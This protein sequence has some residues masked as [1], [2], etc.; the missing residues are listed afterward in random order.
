MAAVS[1]SADAYYQRYREGLITRHLCRN[2]RLLQAVLLVQENE[3]ALIAQA[4]RGAEAAPGQLLP[5]RRTTHERTLDG[6][7]Y[8]YAAYPVIMRDRF[9]IVG[10]GDNPL[11]SG[12]LAM[13]QFSIESL[14]GVSRHSLGYATLLLK[15]FE[16]SQVAPGK[17]MRRR[18]FWRDAVP[19]SKDELSGMLLGLTFFLQAT[20]RAGDTAAHNRGKAFMRAVGEYLRREKY[21]PAFCWVFQFPF[22]RLFK[23]D[24]GT[25]LLSGVTIPP[26]P[27]TGDELGDLILKIIGN[28]LL[29]RLWYKPKHLYRD[30][31]R[32][33]PVAYQAA[34]GLDVGRK[35]FNVAMYCHTAQMI[36]DKP[37]KA[38]VRNELWRSFQ[39]MF[40]YFARSG[41]RPG[42]GEGRQNALL[43]VVAHA[44]AN[45]VG[46]R[47]VVARALEMYRPILRPEGVWAPSLP[48]CCLP[49]ADPMQNYYGNTRRYWGERFTWEHR[50]PKGH[51]LRWD[52]TK[53][54]GS[55]GPQ[56]E[57][58]LKADRI[59]GAPYYH[60]DPARGFVVE[61]V[62]QGLP[63][64]RALAAYYG[65]CPAPVL[66]VDERHPVLPLD[67]PAP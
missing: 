61:A 53:C 56:S 38:S 13:A 49:G 30:S 32:Y 42:Q 26:D 24:L 60:A 6:R 34:T 25:A 21:E 41:S 31:M 35:F 66:S 45:K 36:F 2:G 10:G 8:R 5:H 50:D 39:T 28:S 46:N 9:R 17:L 22:T 33:L 43:G 23:F 54:L 4:A 65:L 57:A 29:S 67:G 63:V 64:V 20:K 52:W 51:V 37:V 40:D 59:V 47:S 12:G 62:G 27:S 16:S 15:F 3:N 1:P 18:N 14:L 48:L 11:L 44:F 58:E 7:A 19:V 55:I